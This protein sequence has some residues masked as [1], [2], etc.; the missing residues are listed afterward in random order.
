MK[1]SISEQKYIC[2]TRRT[3]QEALGSH[4]S[5]YRRNGHRGKVTVSSDDEDGEGCIYLVNDPEVL[6]NDVDVRRTHGA[7][8]AS[9]FFSFRTPRG[10]S[11]GTPLV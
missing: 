1:T 7:I 10:F 4:P 9:M 6:L 11:T 3:K 2:T 8:C 5:R